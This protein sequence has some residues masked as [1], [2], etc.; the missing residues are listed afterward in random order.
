MYTFIHAQGP[1][2][3]WPARVNRLEKIV[4]LAEGEYFPL[5]SEV[6]AIPPD[7]TKSAVVRLRLTVADG[8]PVCTLIAF[9]QP[10]P[11]SGPKG[12]YI[13]AEIVG[14]VA[15]ASLIDEAVVWLCTTAKFKTLAHQAA[16]SAPVDEIG[17]VIIPTDESGRFDFWP[18]EA[19]QSAGQKALGLRRQ[20]SVDDVLLRRVARIYQE[21]EWAPTEA[22][23]DQIPTS[24][25]NATRYVALAR[26]RGFLPPYERTS[27][28]T[29]EES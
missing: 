28:S 6:L 25:R 5:D 16:L 27:K 29:E 14:E 19:A 9:E 22:V 23:K 17:R 26:E 11:N 1:D 3:R 21:T 12:P 8:R 2:G 20:R 10:V 15:V 18:P 4:Q 24:K 7:V 13:E